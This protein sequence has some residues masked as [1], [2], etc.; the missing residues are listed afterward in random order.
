MVP[1]EA[2]RVETIQDLKNLQPSA[3]R[4]VD[5]EGYFSPSDAG[6]GTF[7]FKSRESESQV[8]DG[9]FFP[10]NRNERGVWKRVIETEKKVNVSWYGAVGDGNKDDTSA[11]QTVWN[12]ISEIDGGVVS[13]PNG[14]Y[15]IK[16]ELVLQGV[17]GLYIK[18]FGFKNSFLSSQNFSSGLRFLDCEGIEIRDLAIRGET[19]SEGIISCFRFKN[20]NQII[21]TNCFGEISA[22]NFSFSSCQNSVM[23]NCESGE[24]VERNNPSISMTAG[25][26]D[27]DLPQEARGVGIVSDDSDVKAINSSSETKNQQAESTKSINQGNIKFANFRN[28]DNNTEITT[29]DPGV[30]FRGFQRHNPTDESNVPNPTEGKNVFV[31]SDGFL[32]SKDPSG[33]ISFMDRKIFTDTSGPTGGEDGDIFFV[34]ESA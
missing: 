29:F 14:D 25:P 10:T 19:G 11:F 30:T 28:K 33:E 26:P 7:V 8:D 4:V 22:N 15:V 5:V 23:N 20:T 31:D 2:E 3:N 21:L 9:I 34:I 24:I 1:E 27:I 32:K 6:G 17:T 12:H 16:E 18:G 13:V